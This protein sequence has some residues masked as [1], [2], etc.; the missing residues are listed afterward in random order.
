MTHKS[1]T[2]D[3]KFKQL[4]V[5]LYCTTNNYTFFTPSNKTYVLTK[6]MNMDMGNC[7][8]K[9]TIHKRF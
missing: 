6:I 7:F 1:G 4:G 5:F 2:F 3:R 8:I 9:S